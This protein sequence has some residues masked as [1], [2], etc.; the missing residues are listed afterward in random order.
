MEEIKIIERYV[1]GLTL[2][3][4]AHGY[5]HVDRVRRWGLLIAGKEGYQETKRVEAAALLHDIGLSKQGD[6]RNHGDVSAEMA[7]SFLKQNN[8]FPPD[9][10]NEIC[11]AIRLHNRKL[12]RANLLSAILMDAD[13]LDL[14]GPIGLLRSAVSEG[15]HLPEYDVQNFRTDAWKAKNDFFD[16]R[17]AKSEKI[18]NNMIE[19][20]NFQASCYDN[21]TLSAS[22]KL[23]KPYA[24]YLYRFIADLESQLKTIIDL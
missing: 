12:P 17:Y 22:K 13:I 19:Q 2:L 1:A 4:E 3:Q 7:E 23:A 20:L 6:R 18:T 15:G 14:L 9:A 5:S 16:Q 8:L 10:I 11:L 21:L 24:A